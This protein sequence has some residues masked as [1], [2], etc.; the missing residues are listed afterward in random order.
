MINKYNYENELE[1]KKYAIVEYQ[2]NK[3]TRLINK[4][5]ENI[6]ILKNN[7]EYINKLRD[8]YDSSIYVPYYDHIPNT[9]A[10]IILD[11]LKDKGDLNYLNDTLVDV[12]EYINI[13][14]D[15]IIEKINEEYQEV[16]INE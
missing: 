4:I 3:R 1:Y 7:R 9:Y 10:Y 2:K 16:L 8:E 11:L 15:L 6:K 12:L 13:W 14:N 5:N